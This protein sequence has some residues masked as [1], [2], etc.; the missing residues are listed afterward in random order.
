MNE[1][2]S[3]ADD[4]TR[5]VQSS[6]STSTQIQDLLKN[7]DKLQTLEPPEPTSKKDPDEGVSMFDMAAGADD[8]AGGTP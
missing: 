5:E 1:E 6:K 2:E 4:Q 7:N 8:D 3:E